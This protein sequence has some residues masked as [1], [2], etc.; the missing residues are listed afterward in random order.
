MTTKEILH[1]C[2][3]KAG[4]LAYYEVDGNSSNAIQVQRGEN[5]GRWYISLN[6][7]MQR[8]DVQPNYDGC[9][10]IT[11]LQPLDFEEEEQPAPAQWNKRE[12]E[13]SAVEPAVK[14]YMESIIREKPYDYININEPN[15]WIGDEEYDTQAQMVISWTRECWRVVTG[16][17]NEAT[18]QNIP[19]IEDIISQLPDIV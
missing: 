8:E 3:P 1:S 4:E 2:A 11:Y 13:L 10:L 18:E 7:L 19:T 15:T 6:E 14:Q 17:V 16:I 9:Y 5:I 12:W